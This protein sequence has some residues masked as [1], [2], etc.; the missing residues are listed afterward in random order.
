ML[1]AG[2]GVGWTQSVPCALLGAVLVHGQEQEQQL[3]FLLGVSVSVCPLYQVLQC[4]NWKQGCAGDP[5]VVTPVQGDLFYPLDANN[6][7]YLEPTKL[8]FKA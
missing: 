4:S 5:S 3:P 6:E 7:I 8:N 2:Q 1:G